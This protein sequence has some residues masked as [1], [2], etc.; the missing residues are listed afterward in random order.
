MNLN[1]VLLQHVEQRRLAGIVEAEEQ[2]LALLVI[3]AQGR[4]DVEHPIYKEHICAPHTTNPRAR[5][6]ARR[7][8]A[9]AVEAELR[10]SAALGY[11]VRCGAR[12]GVTW[13]GEAGEAGSAKAK[14]VTV[15]RQARQRSEAPNQNPAKLPQSARRAPRVVFDMRAPLLLIV[16]HASGTI[17]PHERAMLR[18]E[19]V[20][21]R[22]RIPALRIPLRRARPEAAQTRGG[23][24]RLAD[25]Q[26][27]IRRLHAV[28]V[29]GR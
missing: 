13:R 7:E 6:P 3:K 21:V 28:R 11:T 27:R 29:P 22:G 5:A 24:R 1:T 19:T 17:T 18:D 10:R 16:L 15:A 8:N 9:R 14:L 25:V 12:V 26:A 20:E 4:E 23:A 2:N